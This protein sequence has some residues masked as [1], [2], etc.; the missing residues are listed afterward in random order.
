M[1]INIYSN[2]INLAN[3]QGSIR[4]TNWEGFVGVLNTLIN[5]GVQDIGFTKIDGTLGYCQS[6]NALEV[7]WNKRDNMHE[8]HIAVLPVN[9]R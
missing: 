1:N 2:R 3:L 9:I 6:Q 8:L 4:F 7:N 5:N